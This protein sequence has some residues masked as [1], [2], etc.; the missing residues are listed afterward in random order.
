MNNLASAVLLL[1]GSLTAV[2]NDVPQKMMNLFDEA[3]A[4]A[5]MVSTAGDLKTMSTMLDA[6]YVMNRRLP[7][8]NEF[9]AWLSDTFKE[10]NVKDLSVDHWGS[11]YLYLLSKDGRQY[12]LVSLGPDRLPGTADDMKRTGP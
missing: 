1:I 7:R 10:N 3:V 5:Q 8:Q 12:M 4:A 2:Y 6:N 9:R 11:P